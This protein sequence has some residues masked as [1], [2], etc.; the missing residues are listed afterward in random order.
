MLPPKKR[1]LDQACTELNEHVRDRLRLKYY[2]YR[3][4][5]FHLLLDQTIHPVPQQVPPCLNEGASEWMRP[6]PSCVSKSRV[7]PSFKSVS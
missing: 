1:L 4:E 2:A 5:K 7:L 6:S 3:I